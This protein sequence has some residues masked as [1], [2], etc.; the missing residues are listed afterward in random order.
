M[1]ILKVDNLSKTYGAGDARVE[2]LKTV[3]FAMEKGEFSAVVG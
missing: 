3:S 2:A 1:E